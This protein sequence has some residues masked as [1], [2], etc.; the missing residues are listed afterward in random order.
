MALRA[1]LIPNDNVTALKYLGGMLV[2]CIAVLAV[3]GGVYFAC[4]SGVGAA[5]LL[6][7]SILISTVVLIGLMQKLSAQIEQHVNASSTV[8]LG[9]FA[10]LAAS[11]LV[12]VT[13]NANWSVTEISTV[14]PQL[15]PLPATASE[16]GAPAE[17]LGMLVL[18]GIALMTADNFCGIGWLG[19]MLAGAPWPTFSSVYDD[20]NAKITAKVPFQPF[21]APPEAL[22]A[23][24]ESRE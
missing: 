7:G 21:W 11:C 13:T 23:E 16:M 3:S 18:L 10:V 17:G 8:V 9:F 24:R 2:A 1:M 12:L 22:V 5:S 6:L 20:F 19:S 15:K 4:P 14:I